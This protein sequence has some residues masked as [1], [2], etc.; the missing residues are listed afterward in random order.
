MYKR[1]TNLITNFRRCSSV[2]TITQITTRERPMPRTAM[3]TRTANN[4]LL[5][6]KFIIKYKNI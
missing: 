6:P 5:A 3:I 4:V 2:V 1:Q